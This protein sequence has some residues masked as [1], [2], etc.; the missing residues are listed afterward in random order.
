M[1]IGSGIFR[2]GLGTLFSLINLALIVGVIYLL[3]YLIFV[4]PKKI[5]SIESAVNNNT[6]MLNLIYEKLE[7]QDNS[8]NKAG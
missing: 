5:K 7:E 6:K 3:Y 2:F 4:L 8:N 1:N